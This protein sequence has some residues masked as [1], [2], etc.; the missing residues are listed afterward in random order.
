MA[1]NGMNSSS[2]TTM[3]IEQPNNTTWWHEWYTLRWG[4]Y[5]GTY[6]QGRYLLPC[7]DVECDRLDIM[8]KFFSVTRQYE[9]PTFGGLYTYRLPERPKVLDLGCGT[10]IWAIDIADRHTGQGQIEGWDLN[11]TQP[12]AIPPNVSF[13]RRDFEDPWVGVEPNSLDLVH[14]R[15]LN[16]SVENWPRLYNQVFKHLKPGSGYLEQVEIDWRPQ[17]DGDPRPLAESK[18]EEWSQKVHRGFARAGRN[19]E[20]DP[21]TGRILEDLGFTVEHKTILIALN[22]W[23][24]QEHRKEMA[25]W[26]NLGLNQGLE[27]MTF[28]SVIH[29]LGYPEQEVRELIERVKEDMCKREWRTYCTM[30]IYI[31]RRPSLPGRR[32]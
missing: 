15:M 11:L 31:A 25:R 2:S 30:H 28:E 26:F 4:R 6:K 3:A 24:E 7:D 13:K 16:G 14:M 8:H 19:L 10:G 23:P 20:M 32:A 17:S 18:L 12:E 27:A 22:P 21:N 1:Y 29:W 5:Y 9:D